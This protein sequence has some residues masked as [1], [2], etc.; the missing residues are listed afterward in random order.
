MEDKK[1][2]KPINCSFYDYLEI[3][4]MCKKLLEI[5]SEDD[6]N[7]EFTVSTR[8]SN[9]KAIDGEEFISLE[10]GSVCRLDELISI[11]PLT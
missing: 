2:Y 7:A 10:N 4:A 8:I 3:Y 6:D 9:V 5:K 11:N 1:P